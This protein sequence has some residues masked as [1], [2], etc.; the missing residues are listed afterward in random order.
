MSTKD[1]F[2]LDLSSFKLGFE[3]YRKNIVHQYK[4][5]DIDIDLGISSLLPI[6][7]KQHIKY[8]NLNYIPNYRN[9]AYPPSQAFN[10][11][12]KNFFEKDKDIF[13]GFVQMMIDSHFDNPEIFDIFI[14]REI[15]QPLS[16][17]VFNLDFYFD[18]SDKKLKRKIDPITTSNINEVSQ[19]LD[20]QNKDLYEQCVS[21]FLTFS[22][23]SNGLNDFYHESLDRMK[24]IIENHLT[25]NYA[26]VRISNKNRLSDIIFNGQNEDFKSILE[27]VVK[28]IHHNDTGNR[29][30][31]NQKEYIYIWLELNKILYLLKRY[32]S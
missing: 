32:K 5:K 10:F 7:I 18:E 30:Q 21:E 1:T 31:L 14:N 16:N 11:V 26:D 23:P 29:I 27:Y 19:G 20:E 3:D 6:Q 24:E 13:L 25:L 22:L 17:G 2:D 8:R 12:I 9:Y 15:I 28:K 4:V